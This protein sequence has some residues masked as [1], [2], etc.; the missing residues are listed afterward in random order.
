MSTLS[1]LRVGPLARQAARPPCGPR[2]LRCSTC[3]S[4]RLSA[5]TVFSPV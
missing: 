4:S 1:I 2:P 5:P 3:L